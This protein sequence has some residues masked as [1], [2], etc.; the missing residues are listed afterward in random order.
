MAQLTQRTIGSREPLGGTP[1]QQ[2][3]FLG[4]FI[5]LIATAF[6]FIV[7]AFLLT[8]WGV[9]FNLTEAQ[10]GAIA[11]VGLFPFAISIVLF[12]LFIDRVGYGRTMVF[13]WVG[14]VVSAI[15]TIMAKNYAMLY[16]GTLIFAL[17]NG[18]VEAVINPVVAT[19]YP[20]KK[21]H[22]LN[23]LH[24]GWP[25]GMVLAGILA[26]GM[27]GVAWQYKVGLVLIP[28]AVYGILLLG[29]RFPVQE[30]VAAGVSYREMMRE[31]GA[32]GCFILT[33]FLTVAIGTVLSVAHI[34]MPAWL[35]VVMAAGYS[36]AFYLVYQSFGRPMFVFLLI[37]M[38]LL[39]TTELGVD[40][41]VVDLMTPVLR[42]FGPSAG[43]WLLVYTSCI[44]FVLRFFAGPLV[45]RLS[46]LGLLATCAAIAAAG[47][48]W[49]SSAGSAAA[50][51]F[52]AATCYGIGKSF[53]W[54][55]TLGVVAEQFPRG[56]ALT[57]NAMGGMGMIAV[58]VLGGPLL[59]TVL[60][61]RMD[62]NLRQQNPALHAVVAEQPTRNFFMTYQPLEKKRIEALPPAQKEEVDRVVADTKQGML[63]KVALL[64]AI[65]C[66]CYIGLI[67]YFRSRGGYRAQ[68]LTGEEASGGIEGPVEA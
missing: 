65:M 9:T 51:V 61:R 53:F 12:S 66:V 47:L 26:I 32:A 39:A 50:I 3:L 24:A 17:A 57:L 58:G 48:L 62:A 59:G 28:T 52:L 54:P 68:S 40:S 16:T 44:M 5:A 15:L 21:T 23:M 13:A 27:G 8:E 36:I 41:W 63:A 43:A 7:R 4:C 55:T 22:Y 45:H 64:P 14:H 20:T 42:K 30:R 6:G 34:V 46:P 10:K 60:D 56:G 19:L 25:G 29:Q 33:Y 18:A 35:P 38:I 37:V 11:G 49:L 1:S 67:L 2:R 31:F